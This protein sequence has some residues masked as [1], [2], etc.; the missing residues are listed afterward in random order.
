MNWHMK[1]TFQLDMEWVSYE[2]DGD[3]LSHEMR[4]VEQLAFNRF[5]GEPQLVRMV[6]SRLKEKV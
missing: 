3:D 1:F 5:G 4:K 2:L 6:A